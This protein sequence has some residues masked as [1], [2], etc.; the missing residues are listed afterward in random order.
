[1]P[2][3][4]LQD[5][6]RGEHLN[7]QR[8]MLILGIPE[9]CSEDDF[10]ETVHAALRHLGRYRVI[11]R[12][13]RREENAQASL[14][15]FAEDF[16]C[17]SVPREIVGKG[18]PW[19]VIVEPPNSDGEFLTRLNHLLEEERRTVSDINRILGSYTNSTPRLAFNPEVWNWAQTLEVTVQPLLEQM[20]YRELRVFSGNTVAVPGMSA[21]EAWFEHATDMLQMWQ[22]PEMEKRRRLIECLRGPALQVVSVLRANNA[23][24]TVK[25]C[26][27]A[28][29]QVFG[30]VENGKMAQI[31]FCKA[32]QEP[33]EKVSNFVVRLEPLLQKAIE[34]KVIPRKNVNQTRLKRILGG[35]TLTDTLRDKLKL[36][37]QR[38]KPP[39]FLALVKLLREEEEWEAT[40]GPERE[41]LEGLELSPRS[42]NR[43]SGFGPFVPTSDQSV[44]T[45]PSQGSLRRRRRGRRGSRGGK[46]SVLG[47]G[48][49]DA[50]NR[51]HHT[52]CYSCGEDGHIRVQCFNPSN[53]RL[54]K[55]TKDILEKWKGAVQTNS[56]RLE[57]GR[58]AQLPSPGQTPSPFTSCHQ[59]R[60]NGTQLFGGHTQGPHEV[61][62]TH[63]RNG[64]SWPRRHQKLH[65]RT[66]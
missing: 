46:G 43:V 47:A 8:S 59:P 22:V 6:C 63:A 2:L 38:R 31:K 56:R 16:D 23:G 48:S 10:Q 51:N 18:G 13:F 11:G 57:G 17:S 1:M 39:G 44:E 5:W 62:G 55:Q 27:Q 50:G 35:A 53:L 14:L 60:P 25:E 26:L 30:P 32:Y 40:M 37:K 64:P 52:F 9:D 12:M 49:G 61:S 34:K 33:G 45:W 20:L 54:V 42:P 24:V 4:L 28:L 36:M 41:F 65:Y 15:E 7:S 19:E 21:F 29:Q 66:Q 3:T 58:R